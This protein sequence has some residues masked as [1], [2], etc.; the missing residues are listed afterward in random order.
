MKN[1]KKAFAVVTSLFFMWGFI[2]VL[3]D[4][5]IPRLKETFELTYAQSSFVQWAWF[6]AYC[7]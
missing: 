3:V 7:R 1:Y 5:L 2:T 4:G 6:L